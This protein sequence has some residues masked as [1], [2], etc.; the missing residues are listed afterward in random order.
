M[1]PRSLPSPEFHGESDALRFW[2]STA[3]QASVGASVSRSVLHYRF[4]G[5]DDGSD[6]VSVYAANR[7]LID[8]AV[9]RRV[10]AGSREPVMVREH[11]LP[12]PPR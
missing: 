10:V 9:L 11:D 2:V 1:T 7:A 4:N 12:V 5:R 8:A 6:A 3:D